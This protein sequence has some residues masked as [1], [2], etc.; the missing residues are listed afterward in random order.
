V[1]WCVVK[2]AGTT[3][4]PWSE[5][6][7]RLR[8]LFA[9]LLCGAFSFVQPRIVAGQAGTSER[10]AVGLTLNFDRINNRAG[11]ISGRN[12]VPSLV[13][14]DGCFLSRQCSSAGWSRPRRQDGEVSAGDRDAGSSVHETTR[15]RVTTHVR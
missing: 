4:F 13:D 9:L 6:R 12:A 3:G 2:Q 7:T 8:S 14:A 11:S 10:G 5:G 15:R 1:R